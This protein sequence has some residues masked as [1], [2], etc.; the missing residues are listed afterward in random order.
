MIRWAA[1]NYPLL[2]LSNTQRK[3]KL[4]GLLWSLV[5]IRSARKSK[6]N[7]QPTIEMLNGYAE[8][9]ELSNLIAFNLTFEKKYHSNG[10]QLKTR[11][12]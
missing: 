10:N 1:D 3:E 2:S 9:A 12:F 4:P 8:T 5:K 6:P 7:K 11:K